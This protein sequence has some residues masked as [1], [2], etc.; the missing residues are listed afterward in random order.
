M[1]KLDLVHGTVQISM[2]DLRPVKGSDLDL[3]FIH[4]EY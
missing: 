1:R 4:R 3:P 2:A